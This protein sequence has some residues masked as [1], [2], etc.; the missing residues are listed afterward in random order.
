MGSVSPD[1]LSRLAPAHAPP[2]PGWWPPAPGWWVVMIM[3]VI[4]IAA[5]IYWR[6]R[7]VNRLRR[8]A[9]HELKHIEATDGR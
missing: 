5:A 3:L 9:L 2:P 4:A 8:I 1:W 6:R 7:P